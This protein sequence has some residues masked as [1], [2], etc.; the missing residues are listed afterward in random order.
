MNTKFKLC[1]RMKIVSVFVCSAVKKQKLGEMSEILPSH[2]SA[3]NK[4]EPWRSC[5]ATVNISQ[6]CLA[7]EW[8]E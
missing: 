1:G 3:E 4:F 7:S 2:S 5:S 6:Y 8:A